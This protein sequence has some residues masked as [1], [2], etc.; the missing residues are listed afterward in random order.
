MDCSHKEGCACT[1]PELQGD[2]ELVRLAQYL[3]GRGQPELA[4]DTWVNASQAERAISLYAQV[5]W[6]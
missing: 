4:A 3:E 2:D 5:R 6:C 1:L